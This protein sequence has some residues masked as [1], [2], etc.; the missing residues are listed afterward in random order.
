MTKE[1]R[2]HYNLT[3]SEL[4]EK[5]GIT[6]SL[7]SMAE[8]GNRILPKEVSDKLSPL[9]YAIYQ[10]VTK[11]ADPRLEEEIAKQSD[12]RQ[13]EV[14]WKLTENQYKIP[15][16]EKQLAKMKIDQARCREI[17]GSLPRIQE[18]MPSDEAGL[19]YTIEENTRELQRETNEKNQLD[20]ELQ[21]QQLKAEVAYLNAISGEKP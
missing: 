4:A 20:I 12:A 6:R 10:P 2:L 13:K 9:F 7:L 14:K 18:M 21:V 15:L 1:I 16:L 17:L 5:L 19:L 8:G 3:Q 11:Q